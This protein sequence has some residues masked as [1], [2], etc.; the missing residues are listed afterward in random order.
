MQSSTGVRV[1]STSYRVNSPGTC[2]YFGPPRH[3]VPDMTVIGMRYAG[4]RER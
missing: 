4:S 1:V 3:G 2:G